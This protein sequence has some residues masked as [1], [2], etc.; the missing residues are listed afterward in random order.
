MNTNI[1]LQKC[2]DV[3]NDSKYAKWYANIINSALARASSK[4]QANLILGYCEGH[5]IL[6]VGFDLGG[7]KDKDNYVFLSAREHFI[8]HW[9]LIKSCKNPRHKLMSMFAMAGFRQN[10][11]Q[12]QR[13]LTSW[14]FEKT[15]II[16]AEATRISNT[17]RKHPPRSEEYRKKLSDIHKGR[18]SALRGRTVPEETK[19]KLKEAWAKRKERGWKQVP[20][21]KGLTL[22]D[23][24]YK[25]ARKNKGKQPRLGAVLSDETKLKMSASLKGKTPWNKGKQTTE[26]ICCL[27]CKREIR[28]AG[29]FSRWHGDNCKF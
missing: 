8:A 15:R 3:L 22:T 14:E 13:R 4:K 6:P 25:G 11:G 16:S 2:L 29:T 26:V 12:Q 27:K 24:K 21:N 1:Y 18:P 17:G 28:G 9:L 10:N 5:H 7:E 19:E 20:W 23:E